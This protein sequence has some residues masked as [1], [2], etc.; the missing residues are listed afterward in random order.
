MVSK[1]EVMLDGQVLD[2][3]RLMA[4]WRWKRVA[5]AIE[6]KD[7]KLASWNVQQ[8]QVGTAVEWNLGDHGR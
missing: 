7:F 4:A 5:S 1:S 8:S 2:A 3:N 6:I